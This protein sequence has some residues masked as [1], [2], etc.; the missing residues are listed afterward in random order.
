MKN[1]KKLLA[2]LL[3]GVMLVGMTACDSGDSEDGEKVVDKTTDSEDENTD[4]GNEQQPADEDPYAAYENLSPAQVLEAFASA[5]EASCTHTRIVTDEESQDKSYS[6]SVMKRDGDLAEEA[7]RNSESYELDPSAYYDFGRNL[8]YWW[9][10]SPYSAGWVEGNLDSDW[11]TMV[12]TDEG[13]GDLE[14]FFVDENYVIEGDRWTLKEEA[15]EGFWYDA[16]LKTAYM[17]SSGTTYTF[18]LEYTDDGEFTRYEMLFE[19]ADI[20]VTLP[21][22]DTLPKFDMSARG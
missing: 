16:V 2:L 6:Q 8:H 22:F 11:K 19:F 3:A 15:G 10:Y 21:D 9:T 12:E 4:G 20:T 18:V 14:I 13:F 5:E 17:E 7:S 1:M